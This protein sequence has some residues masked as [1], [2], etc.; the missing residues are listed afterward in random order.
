MEIFNK[1]SLTKRGGHNAL[2]MIQKISDVLIT[3]ASGNLND[4][5]ASWNIDLYNII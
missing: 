2:G 5:I 3:Y 4:Y 1:I